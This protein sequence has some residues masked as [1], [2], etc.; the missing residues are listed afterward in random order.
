MAPAAALCILPWIRVKATL[1][2][3][4][5]A[6]LGLAKIPGRPYPERCRAPLVGDV[7]SPDI[8]WT[9]MKLLEVH[10][11]LGLFLPTLLPCALP[12]GQAAS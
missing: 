11:S 10:C 2:R 5:S 1:P 8:P 4:C 9:L 12:S 7:S 6:Q 3:L